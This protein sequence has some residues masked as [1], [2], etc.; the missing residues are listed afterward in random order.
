MLPADASS[1]QRNYAGFQLPFCSSDEGNR[2]RQVETSRSRASGVKVKYAVADF[3]HSL[4]RMAGDDGRNSGG[5]G[6]DVEVGD[7][8]D[9]IEEVTCQLDQIGSGKFLTWAG[10]VNVPA[11]RSHGSYTTQS[12]QD[13]NLANVSRV[14]DVI[15]VCEAGESF[16]TQEAVGIANDTDSHAG[17]NGLR[18]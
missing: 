11:D 18:I 4:M 7:G 9:E 17:F 8:V 5:S 2:H 10:G 1:S 15:Y 3:L 14:Q 16:G 13:L 12:I 6:I